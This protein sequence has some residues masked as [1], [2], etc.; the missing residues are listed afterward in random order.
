MVSKKPPATKVL[1][2]IEKVMLVTKKM[3]CFTC[4]I[5]K[6]KFQVSA[7][8]ALCRL[9]PC[10]LLSAHKEKISHKDLHLT[11]AGNSYIMN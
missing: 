4:N 11:V 6:H 8:H 7:S 9:L 2:T 3:K 1:V 10:K 5:S